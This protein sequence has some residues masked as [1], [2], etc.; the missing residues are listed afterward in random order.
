MPTFAEIF[1]KAFKDFY[2][3][4]NFKS[5]YQLAQDSELKP[6]H[7]SKIMNNPILKPNEETIKKLAQ[8]FAT[9]NQTNIEDEKKDIEEF[10]QEW[11]RR[12]LAMTNYLSGN[13]IQE[14]KLNLEVTVNDL[15]Y[16]K[17][18]LLPEIMA[19]LE[20]V[21]QGMI[22]VKYVKKGSI[23]LGLESFDECYQRIR[24]CYQR[25]E[26]SELLGFPVANLQIQV[27]LTQWFE[28]IFETGWQM[29]TELLNPQ[30]LQVTARSQRIE[31]GKLIDLQTD[32]LTHS[33]VLLI[34]L[35]R[36]NDDSSTVKIKLRVYPTGN[37][38]YLPPSLKLLVLSD[39]QVFEEVTAIS[40]DTFIQCQF[41]GEVEEEFTVQLV[42]GE[43]VV[44]E[45]FVI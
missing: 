10:F 18:N 22:I 3:N 6:Y 37:E 30:Q 44:T 29:V 36:E 1:A 21:G 17:E 27:T 16:F 23:I 42:L 13:P 4:K 14:W 8:S 45:N 39:N 19:K 34:N 28:G 33:V 35:N 7:I 25:G 31:R 40:S 9:K 43:A 2:N 5:A 12:K 26:L 38:V 11:R 41:E 32:L 15:S 20:T 24:D